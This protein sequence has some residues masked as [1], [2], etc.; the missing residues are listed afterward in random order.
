MVSQV[1]RIL[2][3]ILIQYYKCLSYL[4]TCTES[5]YCCSKW[6][7]GMFNHQPSTPTL[8]HG[9]EGLELWSGREVRLIR[10]GEGPL[11]VLV[12]QP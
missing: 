11:F 2:I 6:V 5:F 4:F 7:I 10:R 9:L 12:F 8:P 3:T 1:L